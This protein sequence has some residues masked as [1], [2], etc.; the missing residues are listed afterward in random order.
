A[1]PERVEQEARRGG[2]LPAGQAGVPW[3]RHRRRLTS[4]LPD[5][6]ESTERRAT[7]ASPGAH[8][9]LTRL[10]SGERTEVASEAVG[11]SR[12]PW[13][14]ASTA[15]SRILRAR[16]FACCMSKWRIVTS[17]CAYWPPPAS[18]PVANDHPP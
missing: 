12:A 5:L 9:F 10:R 11:H 1:V 14:S 2:A 18:W 4:R 7:R 16:F 15:G 17:R 3:R 6:R 8:A 13:S